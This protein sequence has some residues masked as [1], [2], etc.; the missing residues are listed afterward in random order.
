MTRVLRLEDSGGVL[1]LA[2]GEVPAGWEGEAPDHQ[3]SDRGYYVIE[4]ELTVRLGGETTRVGA[5]GFVFA[6]RGVRHSVGNEGDR[7]ARY[8]LIETPV[9]EAGPDLGPMLVEDV[10]GR[11]KVLLRSADSAGRIAV[12]DNFV[13]AGA[14]GPPLHHHDFDEAFFILEG[15]A[16]FQLGDELVTRRAGELVW[17]PRGAHHAFA[18]QSGA[19][20]RWLLICTPAGFERYFQRMAAEEA[21]VDPPPEALEPWPEVTVVGPHI[22]EAT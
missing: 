10:P 12:M 21:G 13:P 19:D 22:G 20:I 8:V 15:E 5:G 3:V 16:T 17:A 2:E 14:K 18:N 11:V 7:P 4:G 9:P 6:P 1:A